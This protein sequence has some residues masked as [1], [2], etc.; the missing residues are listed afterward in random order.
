M[1]TISRER[2]GLGKKISIYLGAN[3][4]TS[5]FMYGKWSKIIVCNC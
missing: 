4:M 1:V 2:V 3:I 5:G